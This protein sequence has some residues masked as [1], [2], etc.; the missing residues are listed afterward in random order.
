MIIT[1][2][3]LL[4]GCTNPFAPKLIDENLLT[5]SFLTDQKSPQDVLSN[6]RYAYIFK[7]SLIYSEILDSS[8][9]GIF[10]FESSNIN[11]VDNIILNNK[12]GIYLYRSYKVNIAGNIISNNKLYAID[13][14]VSSNSNKKAFLSVLG[15]LK[16]QNL[17]F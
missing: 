2:I 10:S 12:E 13:I 11:I 7:D 1:I 14:S 15:T 9:I 8:F 6:F 5:S 17:H 4:I 16:E 3:T